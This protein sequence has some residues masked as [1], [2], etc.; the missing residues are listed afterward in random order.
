MAGTVA[1]SLPAALSLAL[2]CAAHGQEP[3]SPEEIMRQNDLNEDGVIT[4]SEADEA[5]TPLAT[6][7]DQIDTNGDGR[8]TMQELESM[9]RER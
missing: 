8:I 1:K 6:L 5:G 2:L 9:S 4:R 3:P 7:F